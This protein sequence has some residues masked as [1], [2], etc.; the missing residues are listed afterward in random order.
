MNLA[1][2]LRSL[3]LRALAL[4]R[5]GSSSTPGILKRVGRAGSDGRRSPL[6]AFGGLLIACLWGAMGCEADR[7]GLQPPPIATDPAKPDPEPP[8]GPEPEPMPP[9]DAGV[10]DTAP[11]QMG[12]MDVAPPDRPPSLNGCNFGSHWAQKI[13]PEIMLVFDRSSAMSKPATGGMQSRWIEMTEGVATVLSNRA[14]AAWGLKLYPSAA[15]CSMV[16][17]GAEVPVGVGKF[18]DVITR[19][20]GSQPI[21]GPEGSPLFQGISTAARAFTRGALP[22]FMV[23]ASNGHAGCPTSPE[24]SNAAITSI[25]VAASSQHIW[26]FVIGTALPGTPAHDLLNEL[27]ANGREPN[28][29]ATR[30]LVAQNKTQMMNALDT[31]ADRLSSCLFSVNAPPSPQNVA[32]NIMGVRVPRDSTH[33]EGWDYG[34]DVRV[35]PTTGE[36]KTLRIYGEACT[37]L[38]QN[39]NVQPQMIFGCPNVSPP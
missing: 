37:K 1:V 17:D 39:P 3:R 25:S 6:G 20:R 33:T 4:P 5:V 9:V 14:S 8:P 19:I 18:N 38:R 36:I 13:A 26:T 12:S 29:F 21:T 7:G 32:M 23:L 24:A 30:Y 22:R 10:K 16:D 35:P 15:A 28:P 31:I 34:P 2:A 11:V 27:A